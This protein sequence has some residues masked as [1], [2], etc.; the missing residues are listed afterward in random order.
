[1][2][3]L[4]VVSVK[5]FSYSGTTW[6]N[7]VLG[8]HPRA[9]TLG[10]PWRVWGLKD[11]GFEGA[12][13]VHG[14]DSPFWTGFDRFWR[15]EENFLLALA[16]YA[17][18]SHIIF[19][20]PSQAF[21]D[22]VMTDPEIEVKELCYLRDGR[23]ISAS[24][25]RK[26]PQ[27]TYSETLLPHQWLYG[28]FTSGYLSAD[29]GA[30]V[31]RYEQVR[32]DP[33]AFLHRVGL[34][35]GLDYDERSLRFWEWDHHITAGNPGTIAT[36]RLAKGLP[37]GDFP[38]NAFYRDAFERLKRDPR[39]GFEDDR[40]ERELTREDRLSFDFL[41][42]RHNAGYGYERDR[43]TAEDLAALSPK[44]LAHEEAGAFRALG[45]D[46]V[47]RYLQGLAARSA[48]SP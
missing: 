34:H 42:G 7:L 40:W 39:A 23:A 11:R 47:S 16:R 13:R 48:Q 38:A 18:V 4:T 44:L 19:D 15:R 30:P 24:F 33:M 14:A 29:Q 27:F 3:R 12:D 5:A 35:V 9:F 20:N 28:S 32:R 41:L 45:P 37:F 36:V 31:F 26:N 43:F 2:A 25:A 8:S 46:A 21:R 10:P 17:D 1:M 6:C 22:E